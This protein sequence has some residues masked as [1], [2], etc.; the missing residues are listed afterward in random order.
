MTKKVLIFSLVVYL[1]SAV[2]TFTV[3]SVVGK[4]S[5]T[6]SEE[7]QLTEGEEQTLLGALLEID[8]NAP[9]DQECPINGKLYTLP[10]KEAWEKRRPLAVMIENH[11]DARPQ[12]G[13]SSADLVFEAIAEGG[14]TRFMG[15]YYC[16]AQAYDTVLAP[17]RSARTYFVDYASGFN[18]PLY[19][20]VGGANLEGP[21]NA[22]G[23]IGQ[24]GWN[25]ENDLNQFSIGYPTFVRNANRVGRPVA[26][27]HTMESSTE[28]LWAV[29][30][31]R[32]WT[33]MSPER[34]VG[35]KVYPGEDWKDG[36]K[37][38]SFRDEP[39]TGAAAT[40]ISFDFWSGYSDYSVK[41]VYQ[42]DKGTYL[43]FMGG[44]PHLD[45][46]S[47]KQIEVKTA[48][49]LL[50]RER[51]PINELKHMLYDTTGSGNALIFSDGS[52]TKATWVKEERE[53]ELFFT[54]SRGEELAMPR[55]L[56]WISVVDSS[57]D[58]NY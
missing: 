26:T 4:P 16:G 12:S 13:L 45:L 15:I 3:F 34:K 28:K 53:D 47:D 46:N 58:V 27:E 41:Y 43:R 18:Y 21:T 6:S 29:G 40:E 1:F 25:Q 5:L 36:F 9:R 31:E 33:N 20:H 32:G 11:P 8:P 52:V 48:I 51:G 2:A 57:T 54:D 17:I 42:P 22:L 39:M 14:V 56:T 55:G 23:Q 30:E 19:V 49:V 44:E 37:S 50:T 38:W 35:R 10:E 7:I 24:Y